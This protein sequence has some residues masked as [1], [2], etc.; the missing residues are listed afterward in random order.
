MWLVPLDGREP[1][2]HIV[3][4]RAGW[5]HAKISP[6][7]RWLAYVV[8]NADTP[9]IVVQPVAGDSIGPVVVGEG[10]E[11]RW[12]EDGRE[13]FFLGTTQQLMAV[14]VNPGETFRAA[15]PVPLF[16]TGLVIKG[17]VGIL[18][19]NQYVN[20]P[21]GQRFLLNQQPYDEGPSQIVVLVKWTASISENRT[22][23]AR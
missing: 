10:M 5:A 19:G 2:R 15:P 21:D 14:R 7:G 18:G 20:S 3:L 11:P 4:S 9:Q 16:R 12:R 13:L 8:D 6:D 17:I 23:A 22:T 1:P